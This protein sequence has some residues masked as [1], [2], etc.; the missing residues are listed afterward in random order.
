MPGTRRGSGLVDR[1][2]TFVK[3]EWSSKPSERATVEIEPDSCTNIRLASNTI[4]SSIT[5][6]GVTPEMSEHHSVQCSLRVAETTCVPPGGSSLRMVTIDFG[7]E[8]PQQF[9][10]AA[11]GRRVA[12][13]M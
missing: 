5:R 9:V 6:R 7:A 2:K 8:P 10:P 11:F 3:F 4:R 1:L 13:V 12:E